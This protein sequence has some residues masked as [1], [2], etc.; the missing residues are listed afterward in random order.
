MPKEIPGVTHHDSEPAME[1][2]ERVFSRCSE[3]PETYKSTLCWNWNLCKNKDGYGVFR[4]DNKA[5]W[6]THRLVYTLFYGPIPEGMVIDHL[7]YNR[8]CC[9]PEHLD[10]VSSQENTRRATAHHNLGQMRQR[11]THCVKGHLYTEKSTKWVTGTSG[12]SH[13]RCLDCYRNKLKKQRERNIKPTRTHCKHGH[14]FTPENT[15]SYPNGKFYCRTCQKQ[16]TEKY[17][18]KNRC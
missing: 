18:A 2:L 4:P 17:K 12:N 1:L 9:N 10:C 13:R 11:R 3:G 8:K 5:A 15:C 7:C 14:E 16:A 6:R